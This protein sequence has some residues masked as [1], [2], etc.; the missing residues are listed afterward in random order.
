MVWEDSTQNFEF[1][2]TPEYLKLVTLSFAEIVWSSVA[3][4]ADLIRRK[5]LSLQEANIFM[6]SLK[7]LNLKLRC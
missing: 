3:F 1:K 6:H 2:G 5:F 4:S 7:I